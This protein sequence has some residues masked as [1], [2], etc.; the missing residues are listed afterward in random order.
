MDKE[1]PELIIDTTYLPDSVNVQSSED[2]RIYLVTA[3]TENRIMV[4][5]HYKIL[6]IPLTAHSPVNIRID[7]IKNGDYWLYAA[8]SKK[9]V[10]EPAAFSKRTPVGEI[11]IE[12]VNDI[13]IYPNPASVC[14]NIETGSSGLYNIDMKNVN[15]Q[16][17]MS[18]KEKGQNIKIDISSLPKGFYII[19]IK[20]RQFVTTEK[21][22]KL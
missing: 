14:I 6:S 13:K 22:I 12:R 18:E 21:I 2:G 20:S 17:V 15:G 19:T 5:E 1:P 7:T 3:G 11:T 4:I 8:D 16:L 9:N 10:S